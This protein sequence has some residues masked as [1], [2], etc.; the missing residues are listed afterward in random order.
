MG[1]PTPFYLRPGTL[2][3]LRLVPVTRGHLD[4]TR[5]CCA[6]SAIELPG[7][8]RVSRRGNAKF[9]SFYR[10]GQVLCWRGY[11]RFYGGLQRMRVHARAVVVQVNPRAF[12]RGVKPRQRECQNGTPQHALMTPR[13]IGCAH[14]P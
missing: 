9:Y 8:Y 3:G 1:Y 7:G 4:P 11:G 2:E 5:L 13:V 12:L 14:A 10:V 6:W